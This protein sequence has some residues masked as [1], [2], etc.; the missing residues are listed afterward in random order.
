MTKYR[1]KCDSYGFQG[2]Y[3]NK[4]DVGEFTVT[5]IEKIPKVYFDQLFEKIEIDEEE[6]V[7]DTGNTGVDILA[8]DNLQMKNFQQ[9]KKI[10]KDMGVYEDT[11]KTKDDLIQ[12]IEA[13]RE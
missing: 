6:P 12:A 7:T 10:A 13:A 8:G 11:M 4:N 3:W 9:L 5:E 2:R 1:A